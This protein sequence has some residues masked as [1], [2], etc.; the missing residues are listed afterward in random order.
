MNENFDKSLLTILV[1][2]FLYVAVHFTG[3]T[4]GFAVRSIDMLLGALLGIITGK[5]LALHAQSE[6]PAP[7]TDGSQP[8]V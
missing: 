3:D 1:L 6:K 5:H 4:G 2:V 7:P 8:P